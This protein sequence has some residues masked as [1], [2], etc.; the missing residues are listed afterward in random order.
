MRW[1]PWSAYSDHGHDQNIT[2]GWEQ[3][4]LPLPTL[5]PWKSC[6]SSRAHPQDHPNQAL[7]SYE[8]S[9]NDDCPHKTQDVYKIPLNG[10]RLI[11]H[12]KVHPSSGAEAVLRPHQKAQWCR[13]QRCK[14]RKTWQRMS[15]FLLLSA[16][17]QLIRFG[18]VPDYLE[19]TI[20]DKES[21]VIM[22][23]PDQTY[24]LYCFLRLPDS[25]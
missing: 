23:R 8:V 20:Y 2:Q 19:A 6:I 4:P 25:L 14:G 17:S 18:Q 10:K 9:H 12:P 11:L 22:V 24:I 15:H 7:Y 16:F 3:W 13:Q 1:W 5:V 21:A